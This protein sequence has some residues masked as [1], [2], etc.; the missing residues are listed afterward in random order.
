MNE[1]CKELALEAKELELKLKAVREQL[2]IESITDSE[3]KSHIN[4]KFVSKEQ[5][6]KRF[7]NY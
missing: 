5:Y 4:S 3:V 7:D 1:K 6:D 2:N